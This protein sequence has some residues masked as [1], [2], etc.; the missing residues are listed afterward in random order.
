MIK[1]LFSLIIGRALAQNEALIPCEDGS[2]ADPIVGCT[3]TP[4]AIVNAQSDLLAIILKSADALVSIAAAAAVAVLIYG[5]IVYALSMGNEDKIKT[6]KNIL[7]WGIFGLIV[8]LL[9][10]YIV[11]TVL[12]I[13]TQ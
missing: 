12:L 9:A 1:I 6:A 7:F 11:I 13:I 10:K 4:K 2:M 5:G 3:E 8:S